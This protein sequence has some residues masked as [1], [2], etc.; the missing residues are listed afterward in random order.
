MLLMHALLALKCMRR[1]STFAV[2]YRDVFVLLNN[3][4][5]KQASASAAAIVEMR[6]Q[7][8]SD[9]T[10]TPGNNSYCSVFFNL[11]IKYHAQGQ[12]FAS[13]LQSWH[14]AIT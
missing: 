2:I 8:T 5:L 12:I 1:S 10:T 7:T 4:V 6:Y 9:L 14:T 11:H 3:S 13:Y